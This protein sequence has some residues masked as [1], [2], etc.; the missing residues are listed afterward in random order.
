[1]VTE[2]VQEEFNR[3]RD[4]EGLKNSDMLEKLLMFYQAN[5]EVY[6]KG[7]A[8]GYEIARSERHYE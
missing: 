1:M 2:D 8:D 3:L 7:R 5:E 6:E 4:R